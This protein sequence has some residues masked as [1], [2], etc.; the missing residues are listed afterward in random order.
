[1]T[2]TIGREMTQAPVRI[3]SN[4][5]IKEAREVIQMWGMRHLP[6]TDD[7]DQLIGILSD[8]D[9]AR[10]FDSNLNGNSPVSEIMT[11]HPF[12]VYPDAKLYDVVVKMAE[13]KIGSTVIINY[14]R[15]VVGIFTTTDAMKILAKLLGD[16][17]MSEYR[18]IKISD[19]LRSVQAS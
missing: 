16:S 3:D 14:S 5:K 13:S 2:R 1:M 19:Y 8:R 10:L 15:E 4:L 18:T 17:E 12:A 11:P 6:V 7:T 9:F